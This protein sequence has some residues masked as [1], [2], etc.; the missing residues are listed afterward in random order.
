MTHRLIIVPLLPSIRDIS[1]AEKAL[2]LLPICFE[3]RANVTPPNFP[4]ARGG[5]E[6]GGVMYKDHGLN[7]YDFCLGPTSLGTIQF[8]TFFTG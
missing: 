4:L 1:D 8:P 3:N 7:R 6:G 5:A 2:L